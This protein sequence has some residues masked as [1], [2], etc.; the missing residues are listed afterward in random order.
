MKEK[1]WVIY[2]GKAV[3]SFINELKGKFPEEAKEHL[4]NAAREFM[5]AFKTII[6]KKIERIESK[7]AKKVTKVKVE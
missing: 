3:E 4:K 1:E 6:E 7:K 2:L 5:L